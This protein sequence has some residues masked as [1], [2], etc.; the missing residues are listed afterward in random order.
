MKTKNSGNWVNRLFDLVKLPVILPVSLTAFTGFILYTPIFSPPVFLITLGVLCMAASASIINQI[1]ERGIDAIMERTEKRPIP[2][3]RVSLRIAWTL[4]FVF[5]FSGVWLLWTFGSGMA[6][7][8]AILSLVWYNLVYTQLKRVTA[9]AVVPGSLTGALPPL[10]GWTA[11]GGHL[12]D[13]TAVILACIFFIGQVPHF[14]L[15]LLKYGDQYKKAGLP[16]LTDLLSRVQIRRLSF[17]WVAVCMASSLLL[18]I[19]G[20][21]Q[22]KVLALL[23][24]LSAFITLLLFRP[25]LKEGDSIV[26]NKRYFVVLNSYYLVLILLLVVSAF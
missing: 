10:I 22:S 23:L 11:A 18:V 14:W 15:L 16:V 3:G 8:L 26:Y 9:F 25:I 24:L 13:K 17:S 21:I 12:L 20:V 6:V 5:L 7:F 19:F 2:S 4:S 1:Q